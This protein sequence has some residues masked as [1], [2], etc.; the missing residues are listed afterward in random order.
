MKNKVIEQPVHIF[1]HKYNRH[2]GLHDFVGPINVTLY[3]C[4]NECS[5]RLEIPVEGA[6]TQD[7]EVMNV[8]QS[9]R[10]TVPKGNIVYWYSYWTPDHV[11]DKWV[12]DIPENLLG[13]S[14]DV[15]RDVNMK[16]KNGVLHLTIPVSKG[17]TNEQFKWESKI[18]K[19]RVYFEQINQ[20]YIDVKAHDVDEAYVLAI[21]EYEEGFSAPTICSIECNNKTVY[22]GD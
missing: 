21:A 10:V 16:V 19:Y 20:T 15:T 1:Q 8:F 2:N 7:I 6:L 11:N 12:L 9:I 18:E 5:I 13:A 22:D 3:K 17:F 4:P 14:F